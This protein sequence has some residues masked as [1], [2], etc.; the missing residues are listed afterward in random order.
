MGDTTPD[1]RSLH[2]HKQNVSLH[3]KNIFENNELDERSVVKES[4]TTAADS[5]K[6]RRNSTASK[7]SS[8]SATASIPPRRP[9]RQW[10]TTTLKEYLSRLRHE[11]TL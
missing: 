7:P 6:Y 10:A 11:R 2:D 5:K 8:P 9:V 3:L 4:L 1:R